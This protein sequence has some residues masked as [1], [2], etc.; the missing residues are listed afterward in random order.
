MQ[1]CEFCVRMPTLLSASEWYCCWCLE[2]KKHTKTINTQ[3]LILQRP[4]AVVLATV[5]WNG[6]VNTM[7]FAVPNLGPPKVLYFLHYMHMNRN[8]SAGVSQELPK[9]IPIQ[10]PC[11]HILSNSCNIAR[12]KKRTDHQLHLLSTHFHRLLNHKTSDT[13]TNSG[14]KTNKWNPVF[15]FQNPT[16]CSRMSSGASTMIY[17]DATLLTLG[18]MRSTCHVSP[19]HR[20]QVVPNVLRGNDRPLPAVTKSCCFNRCTLDPDRYSKTYWL[21]LIWAVVFLLAVSRL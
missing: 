6:S 3:A 4:S 14:K 7:G 20:C 15:A 18:A 12:K 19:R 1:L 11:I 2:Q 21:I 13:E 17:H 16:V 10:K 8:R 5:F 9:K